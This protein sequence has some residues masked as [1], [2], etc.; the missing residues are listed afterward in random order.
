MKKTLSILFACSIFCYG[1]VIAQSKEEMQVKRAAKG[2]D[3]VSQDELVSFKSDMLY[4]QVLQALSD[5]SKKFAKKPIIDPNPLNTPINQNIESMYW[6]DALELLLRTNN[7]WYNEA[8]D[9][10]QV[11]G[12]DGGGAPGPGGTTV[13][14]VDS[15]A[16]LAKAREVT[17]SAIFLEIDKTKLNESGISFNIFRGKDLNLGVE[18]TGADRVSSNIFTVTAA[19]TSKKLAVDVNAALRI[20][21]SE[22]LGEIIAKPQVTVRS[23]ILGRVQVGA[24]F[25]VKERDF[26]GNIIDKF[27]STGTILEV[28]PKVY[29]YGSTEFIDLSMNVERSNVQPGTVSTIVNRT[30]ATSK[31]VLLNGE[32][33]FVGGLFINEENITREGIPLLK[34][35]PW[36]VFGLRYIFGYDATRVTKKELI[37]LMKAELVPLLDERMNQAKSPRDVLQ[38]KLQEGREDL[39]RRATKKQ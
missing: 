15:A 31:L 10:F 9:Y 3:V 16:I 38:Q 17:I 21:E 29:Q 12:M 14:R 19:P 25:S 20:F 6:K 1:F 24:D 13:A 2:K 28:T 30:K 34:D 32:E 4:A 8:P 22:A 7:R 37:V 35:L 33:S 27:Y 11:V 39:Q 18:F 36:W 26:S 5:M 23:G